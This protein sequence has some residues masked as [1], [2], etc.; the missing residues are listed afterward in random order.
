MDVM[1]DGEF[2]AFEKRFIQIYIGQKKTS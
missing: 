2:N 1:T